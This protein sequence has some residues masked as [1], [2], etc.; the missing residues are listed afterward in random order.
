[1]AGNSRQ[2]APEP[3]WVQVI[4][5][6]ARLWWQ[7]HV[8]LPLAQP[9]PGKHKY[10]RLSIVG[11]A[12]AL[13]VACVAA[14][15]VAGTGAGSAGQGASAQLTDTPAVAAAAAS[16]QQA[17]IWIAAQV[18]HDVIISCDPLMCTALERNGFPAANL[19]PLGPGA[20]DPLGSGIVVSTMAV[21]SQ[22]GSRL[23]SVYAPVVAAS[24][25]TGAG[26]VQVRVIAPDGSANYL[27]A[28]NSDLLARIAAGRELLRNKSLHVPAAA[29]R[30]QLS[31]GQVDSRLLITLAALLHSNP[32]YIRTFVDAGPGAGPA[33]PLRAM[34][35]TSAGSRYLGQV[36]AFLHAQ[37]APLLA[38]TSERQAGQDTVLTIQFSAPSPPGLLTR[39]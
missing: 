8:W 37:R 4:T 22:L 38:L 11:L 20:T 12:V 13:V 33:A 31:A 1:M 10:W 23:A 21:R 30:Q 35:I 7:R 39:N 26:Q 32:V 2:V 24:F 34:A 15:E 25:G 29:A 9:P 5:T 16:R 17:A 6:T 18:G 36:L 27:A 3:P 28:E 19:A 14:V